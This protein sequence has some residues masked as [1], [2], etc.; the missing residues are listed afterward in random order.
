MASSS[1]SRLFA[2]FLVVLF[3]CGLYANGC[4]LSIISFGD[5][6]A[7]TGNQKHLALIS[8]DVIFICGPPYGQNFIGQSTGRC[9]NGR[10][11]IDFLAESLGLPLI[12]PYFN[13]KGSSGVGR[14]GVNYAVVGAT[15]LDASFMEA[16]WSERSVI[17]ASIKIQLAWFKESVSSI[18]GNASD[19]RNFI[20][21]SLI[22][23]GEIG[24]N[25]YNYPLSVGQPI[26]EIEPIVPLVIDAI[27]ST[28]NE[29]IVMGA[30]TLVVP[31]NFP[32]GCL[33]RILTIYGSDN[34]EYDPITG[35]MTKFNKFAEYHNKMLQTKLDHI[36]ERNPNVTLIYADYY[37]ALMQIYRSPYEYG[38][39][40]DKI[41]KAC[42]GCG[43]PFNFNVSMQCG[44]LCKTVCDEPDTY[45]SWDGIHLTE[46]A[47]KLIFKSLFQGPYTIPEFSP[48]CPASS[49]TEVG[50]SSYI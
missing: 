42:C 10:L 45:L 12:P 41:L 31:G 7:D 28:I 13:G 3:S 34:E 43:G 23:M 19:C 6:I 21:R 1:G 29:L 24:G 37:N 38:F 9:S 50:L 5:S 15:A 2:G 4:Y 48:L 44:E 33:P 11:I 22:L 32:L 46:I 20:G 25:D 36:R 30:R 26:D 16:K 14:Q 49:Q 18:C 27:I 8:D 47:Y 39:T 17:N 35:C 40:N